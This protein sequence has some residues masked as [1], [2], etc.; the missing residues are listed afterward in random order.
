MAQTKATKKFEKRHLKDTLQRRKEVAKIKQRKRLKEKQKAR[1]AKENERE[2]ADRATTDKGET[3]EDQFKDMTVDEFFQGGFDMPER[4]SKKKKAKPNDVSA[5]I[6]KRKRI[7]TE[8]DEDSEASSAQSVGAFPVG[9]DSASEAES[10]AD[11]DDHKKQLESL[12]QKDPE[13]YKYM[14]ENDPELLDFEDADLGEINMIS[15][16]E[17]TPKK[18]RKTNK[19]TASDSDE[20]EDPSNE[21]TK[22]MISKWEKA[23]TQQMS[24]RALREVLLA[25]RAAAH[26]NE[27]TG[28]SYKYRVSNPDGR[29]HIPLRHGQGLTISSVSQSS[30]DRIKT[31]ADRSAPSLA[32]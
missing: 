27:E 12:K 5:K 4:P 17:E 19:S 26:L 23:M 25:F 16:D 6:G 30:H 10:E 15:E 32:R 29:E 11:G 22:A 8:E 3:N 9:G 13:F 2:E 31:C 7:T 18:K 24:L 21:V 20:E 1:K 14:K 28:K